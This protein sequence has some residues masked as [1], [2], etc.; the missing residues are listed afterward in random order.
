VITENRSN[1]PGAPLVDHHRMPWKHSWADAATSAQLDT[2][3]ARARAKGVSPLTN[4]SNLVGKDNPR[5]VTESHRGLLIPAATVTWGRLADMLVRAPSVILAGWLADL[6]IRIGDWMFA[7]NDQEAGWRGWEIER[8]Q[9]WTRAPLPRSPVRHAEPV[10]AL[11]RHRSPGR[12]PLRA[13]FGVWP[14]RPRPAAHAPGTGRVRAMA[15]GRP[16]SRTIPA[17]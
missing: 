7:I 13:M 4:I 11:P 6:L 9:R 14:S 16:R 2:I 17:C 8:R 12:R 10:P 3:P 5:A 1:F 15:G